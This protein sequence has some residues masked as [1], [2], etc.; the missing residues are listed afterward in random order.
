ME[1][2]SHLKNINAWTI[3]KIKNGTEVNKKV[4]KK[5]TEIQQK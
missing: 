4:L 2:K 1:L 3:M 5:T